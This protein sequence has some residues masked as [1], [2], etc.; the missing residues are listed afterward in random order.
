MRP[1]YESL[2]KKE[3]VGAEIG[4]DRGFN[5][6]EVLTKM[7]NL[8]NYCLVDPYKP[9]IDPDGSVPQESVDFSKNAA[10][11]KLAKF[12]DRITWIEDYSVN[13]A[14]KIDDQSLDFVYIDGNHTP[15][16][17]TQD[18]ECWLP[19]I[20]TSGVLGGHDW[21]RE[22]VRQAVLDYADTH[23][24]GLITADNDWWFK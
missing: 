17:V 22:D 3:L 4:V 10:K 8:T 12:Q 24:K 16:F 18:I 23:A 21:K 19:K 2:P 20:K 14:T 6:L 9:Y 15:E 13:A 11:E 5:A 7:S 1:F